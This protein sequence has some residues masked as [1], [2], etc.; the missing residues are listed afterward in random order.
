M[1]KDKNSNGLQDR[2]EDEIKEGRGTGQKRREKKGDAKRDPSSPREAGCLLAAAGGSCRLDPP[3]FYS[4]AAFPFPGLSSFSRGSSCP[5][6]VSAPAVPFR[7]CHEENEAKGN[8]PKPEPDAVSNSPG[9]EPTPEASVL[10]LG[11]GKN[12][13]LLPS[14]MTVA[15]LRQDP[16]LLQELLEAPLFPQPQANG[17]CIDGEES[18]FRGQLAAV[19]TGF[20]SSLWLQDRLQGRCWS[21]GQLHGVSRA[22]GGA[23]L[24]WGGTQHLVQG[25]VRPPGT[26]R[27]GGSHLLPLF[28]LPLHQLS[29][30]PWELP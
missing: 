13:Q 10:P 26:Q 4:S 16:L 22:G 28:L 12:E 29:E 21:W 24:S 15:L 23:L 20:G 7:P 18:L 8:P 27:G 5:Q 2:D 6:P 11:E 9:E 17:T 25:V 3:S 1:E 14:G 19:R 30:D